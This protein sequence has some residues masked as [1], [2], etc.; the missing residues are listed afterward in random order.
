MD[1]DA[2]SVESFDTRD[3][4]VAVR[5]DKFNGIKSTDPDPLGVNELPYMI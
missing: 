4:H 2:E 3:S 5:I 1:T